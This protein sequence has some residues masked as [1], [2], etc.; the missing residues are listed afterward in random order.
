M[1]QHLQEKAQTQGLFYF[2]VIRATLTATI[3]NN[4]ALNQLFDYT[5]TTVDL[6]NRPLAAVI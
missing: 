5:A 4:R 3:D 6:F 1:D 2:N